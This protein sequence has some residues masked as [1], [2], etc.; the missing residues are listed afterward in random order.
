M[1]LR[2][3]SSEPKNLGVKSQGSNELAETYLGHR[4]WDVNIGEIAIPTN[5]LLGVVEAKLLATPLESEKDPRLTFIERVA[6]MTE[7]SWPPLDDIPAEQKSTK[8]TFGPG[9]P[10]YHDGFYD[11]PGF[12]VAGYKISLPDLLR[13][14]EYV[15]TNTELD[16]KN[17]DCRPAF[18]EAM[19]KLASSCR[20]ESF[21]AKLSYPK[22]EEP[23]GK[24]D[25]L[26]EQIRKSTGF[27]SVSLELDPRKAEGGS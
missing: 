24:I 11:V 19:K 21:P 23:F 16:L 13:T 9:T 14:A 15:L 17:D 27:T 7:M 12:R 3:S 18:V 25:M 26:K 20:R 6:R 4:K 22:G 1:T 8:L 10:T 5:L 2:L